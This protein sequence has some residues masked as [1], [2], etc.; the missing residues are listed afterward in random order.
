[1]LADDTSAEIILRKLDADFGVRHD[2]RQYAKVSDCL[3]L[4][5]EE[6]S[7]VV[8]SLLG[9]LEFAKGAEDNERTMSG[10][11]GGCVMHVRTTGSPHIL[12]L[13]TVG[14][15]RICA[16]ICR[17]VCRGHKLPRI[18]FDS[19]IF[20]DDTLFDGTVI[21]GDLV[22]GDAFETTAAAEERWVFLADDC[23]A[24]RGSRIACRPFEQ[25][26][27]IMRSVVSDAVYQGDG[28]ATHLIRCKKFYQADSGGALSVLT[29]ARESRPYACNGVFLRSLGKRRKDLLVAEAPRPTDAE[30]DGLGHSVVATLHRTGMPDVY[31]AFDD[32]GRDIPGGVSVPTMVLSQRVRDAFSN[33]GGAP[34]RWACVLSSNGRLV[35]LDDGFASQD[36]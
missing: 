33:N 1:M 11:G 18:V 32:D 29:R 15:T 30:V 27:S 7:R 14:V 17:R 31:K 21:L 36:R 13:T 23:V 3:R 28:W 9:T 6:P 10:S 8:D 4:G 2:A 35:P 24:V 16:Y 12:F 5:D 26:L 22:R 20:R 19:Q 25:R 34:V